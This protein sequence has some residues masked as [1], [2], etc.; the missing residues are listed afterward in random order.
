MASS[1][2]G[3]SAIS[4]LRTPRERDW[5]RPTIL[6]APS[7]LK[8]PTTAHTFEVPT[9]NPTIMED[10]SNM[11]LFGASLFRESGRTGREGAGF[12]PAGR[13]VVGDRQVKRGNLLAH[14]LSLV[15]N[16][17]PAPDLLFDAGQT[18]SDFAALPGGDHQRF[19]RGNVHALDAT[20]PTHGRLLEVGDQLEGGLNLRGFDAPAGQQFLS[21]DA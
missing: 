16:G 19:G 5:P 1:A 13:H 20:E 11:F 12:E 15:K 9:S 2:V 10:A 6:R 21:V 17:A 7:G 14:F 8:S 18:E 3:G 4:P